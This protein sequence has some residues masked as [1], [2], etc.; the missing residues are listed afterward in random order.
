MTY[1]LD[2]NACIRVVNGTSPELARRLAQRRRSE[3]AV[4]SIVKAE[5]TQED[6]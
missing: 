5:L 3:V 1:L 2:A 6:A 4:C